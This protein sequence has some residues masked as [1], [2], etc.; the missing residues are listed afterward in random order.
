MKKNIKMKH[1]K[2]FNEKFITENNNSEIYDE[3]EMRISPTTGKVPSQEIFDVAEMYGEDVEDIIHILHGVYS[4]Y[5]KQKNEDE[6]DLIDSIAEYALVNC[7]ILNKKTSECF[8]KVFKELLDDDLKEK[9]SDSDI[10][11]KYFEISK[12]MTKKEIEN[13]KSFITE[14]IDKITKQYTNKD[15]EF[16]KSK[17]H[18]FDKMYF[19]DEVLNKLI[20]ELK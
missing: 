9:L 18:Y 7:D 14:E 3:L 2:K 20:S 17:I 5:A 13:I 10:E 8:F 19:T 1:L 11:N 6:E 12:Y 15:I 4:D 16:I